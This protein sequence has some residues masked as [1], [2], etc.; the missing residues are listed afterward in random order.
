MIRAATSADAGQIAGI[1]SHYVLNTHITFEEAVVGAD[2]M[3]Q[4]MAEVQHTLPWLVDET[5]GVIDGYC[6]ATKWRVRHA[7]R[8]AAETTIYLRTNVV[9]RGLGTQL[10]ARLLGEL[11]SRG[12]HAA[13][14]GIAL[15]N[16]ASIALHE[17]MGF[18]KVAQFR[19]VGWKF[20]RWI[21][22]GYWEQLLDATGR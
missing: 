22:V 4:R 13:I 18:A 2:E 11:K 7:Y 10:Y 8:F 9:G 17:R 1:Y 3:R 6:Y 19:E 21:D 20:G 12:V 5:D 14:G 16:D 15:P